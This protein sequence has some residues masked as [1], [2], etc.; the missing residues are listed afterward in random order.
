MWSI[1]FLPLFFLINK[2]F[3]IWVFIYL[4]IYY[5]FS[6]LWS[7]H[8]KLSASVGFI[9]FEL[10][11]VFCPCWRCSSKHVIFHTLIHL[12]S[13]VVGQLHFLRCPLIKEL[14]EVIAVIAIYGDRA[15]NLWIKTNKT[16]KY[17]F[18]FIHI[19]KKGENFHVHKL[20]VHQLS[21]SI[22]DGLLPWIR[23]IFFFSSLSLSF[24]K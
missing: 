22:H 4:F 2:W 3:L 13:D 11:V 23:P 19:V 8:W 9:N 10:F 21:Q 16:I 7:C 20:P 14:W 24:V 18:I 5:Y 17:I 1:H 12:L 15:I 6:F